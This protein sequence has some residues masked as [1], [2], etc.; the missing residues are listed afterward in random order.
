MAKEIPILYRKEHP[1][2]D[3]PLGA[4]EFLPIFIYVLVQSEI[5]DILALNEELQAICD[6]DKRLS[7]TGY[8]LATFE[9]SLQHVMEYDTMNQGMNFF[10]SPDRISSAYERIHNHSFSMSTDSE[11][12]NNS[13]NTS[14][15]IEQDYQTSTPQLS[16]EV[17][18]SSMTTPTILG[19]V[20]NQENQ[21]NTTDTEIV[22]VHVTEEINTDMINEQ[23][24]VNE[25]ENL[26]PDEEVY[27]S[28]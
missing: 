1:S 26:S 16:R 18:D 9:A 15:N 3:K 20:D 4:D 17:S 6:P 28:V 2:E 24:S 13:H 19:I 25:A 10:Q 5:P 7:E 21:E 22:N 11:D 14:R 8:Y 23:V 27:A 12:A